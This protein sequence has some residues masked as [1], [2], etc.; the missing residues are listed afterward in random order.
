MGIPIKPVADRFWPRVTKSEGCWMWTGGC[1]STGYGQMHL[2]RPKRSS[3]GAHRVSWELHFG[4]IPVGM[5]VCHHC[6]TRACVRPD[7]LFLGEPVENSR[8]MVRKGRSASGDRHW[9]RLYPDLVPRGERS[10]AR[11]HPES[12][13]R[14]DNHWSRRRPSIVT[15]GERHGNAKLRAA[16]IQ[17]IR[18]LRTEGL[19]LLAIAKQ[20]NVSEQ[21]VYRIVKRT[22]WAHVP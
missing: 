8:D 21:C 20:F 3:V 5:L 1:F 2:S 19:T 13:P 7:H 6:D 15:R 10:G 18:E 12:K 14:G 17:A 11:T 4:P 16:D 9:A 22:S